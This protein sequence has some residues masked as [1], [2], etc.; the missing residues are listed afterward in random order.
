VTSG[1]FGALRLVEQLAGAAEAQ[2]VGQELAYPGWTIHGSTEI[3][4]QRWTPYDLVYLLAVVFPW[5]RPTVGVGLVEGV[6]E[7]EV[8]APFEV[9]AN[10]FAPLYSDTRE[11][12]TRTTSVSAGHQGGGERI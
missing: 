12:P 5:L 9:Y 4:A 10:S 11:T 3:R 2:R 7:L 1:V 6:G 8:A